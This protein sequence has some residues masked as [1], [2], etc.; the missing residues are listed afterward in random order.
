[1]VRAGFYLLVL[2]KIK[3]FLE[4]SWVIKDGEKKISMLYND[5]LHNKNFLSGEKWWKRSR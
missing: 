3:M 4:M 1:M 5:A 2:G